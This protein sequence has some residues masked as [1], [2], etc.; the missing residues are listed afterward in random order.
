MTSDVLIKNGRIEKIEPR[1]IQHRRARMLT[2]INGEGKY[3]FPALL[4]TRF[5]SVNRD[6]T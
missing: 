1:I 6:Y 3:L 5:I 2:E 4:M